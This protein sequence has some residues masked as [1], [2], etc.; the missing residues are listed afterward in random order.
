[1]F[2]ILSFTYVACQQIGEDEARSENRRNEPQGATS[3]RQLGS[4]I[5]DARR[6]SGKNSVCF[7]FASVLFCPQVFNRPP[8]SAVGR[9]VRECSNVRDSFQCVDFLTGR[10]AVQ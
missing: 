9:M 5:R 4:S 10:I 2:D 6:G 8:F 1:M 7:L 3:W